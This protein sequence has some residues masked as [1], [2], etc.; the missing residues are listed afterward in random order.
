MPMTRDHPSYR[1]YSARNTCS[2]AVHI[3]LEEAGCN[4][5]VVPLDFSR[6]EQRHPD[7]LARNPLGRVPVLETSDGNCLTETPAILAYL[8]QVHGASVIGGIYTP[9]EFAR[10]QAFNSFLAST[11]HVAHAHGPRAYRWA[12]DESAWAS[13]RMKVAENML[14]LFQLIETRLA[15]GPWLFGDRYSVCDPYLFVI[16]GWLQ[17]DGVDL[18][19]IPRL[20]AHRER[21]LERAAVRRVMADQP[22]VFA[23]H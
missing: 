5:D 14:S 15:P 21:M 23:S 3:C 19:L 7:H 12:D 9:I 18:S 13:M 4:Y 16:S 6:N 2:L 11:V 22:R 10:M 8:C 17:D 1:L 20:V